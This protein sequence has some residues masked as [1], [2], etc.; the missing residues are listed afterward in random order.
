MKIAF[1]AA[2]SSIHTIRWLNALIQRGHKVYLISQHKNDLVNNLIHPDVCIDYLP[3]NSP[4][5]YVLNQSYLTSIL[6]KIQPDLLHAHYASGYGT[7]AALTNFHPLV[8]SVWGSDI[9]DFPQKSVFHKKLIIY[10]L[11]SADWVCSTS[12]IMAEEV[13][14]LA[15]VNKLSITPFGIDT[16]IFKPRKPRLKNT[17]QLTIGII[18]SLEYKYGVD[19][20]IKAFAQ[21]KQM[22]DKTFPAISDKL[23]LMI[24]GDGTEI[25]N[26]KLLVKQFNIECLTTFMGAVPHTEIPLYVNQLDIYVC[27]SRCEESFGV[28]VLEASACEIPVIVSNKGGLP[29]VVENLVTGYVVE[30]ENVDELV[31]AILKL[32]KN[33]TDRILMGKSGRKRVLEK[34]EWADSVELMENVY[35]QVIELRN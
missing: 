32:I 35:R 30:S 22:L 19:I 21:A 4:F 9:F 10:N 2:Q 24:V 7:L 27:P 33:D 28:S 29:E 13:K 12:E 3:W 14:L 11:N 26:L 23:R 5:G 20:L 1:L 34:Y 31:K 25:K 17:D 16:T 18:K 6:N 8:I 15:R